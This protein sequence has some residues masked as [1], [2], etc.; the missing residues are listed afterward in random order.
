MTISKNRG[1]FTLV[2][3]LVVIAI[4]GTLVGLLLP[5]VQQAREAAR[6]STC[7]NNLKQIGLGLHQYADKRQKNGD[8]MMPMA[9]YSN[10]GSGNAIAS[11]AT[12]SYSWVV[13]IL[14]YADEL[15]TF[16]AIKDSSTNKA[17]TYAA[18]PASAGDNVRIPWAYC[19]TWTGSGKDKSGTAN[20]G[21][22]SQTGQITY[23]AQIGPTGSDGG[24]AAYAETPFAQ[25]RDGTTKTIMLL[26]NA[27]AVAYYQ[28][29]VT[30]IQN[31]TGGTWG[32]SS[33]SGSTVNTGN[34]AGAWSEHPGAL[35]G[36]GMVDGSTRFLQVDMDTNILQSLC[37][38]N[39]AEAIGDY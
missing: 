23:R 8:N 25:Y 26:E 18:V 33:W 16:N 3:L 17:M 32:G 20:G 39:G 29:N 6:R 14:P 11:T 13:L 5:A 12:A 30:W 22:T 35:F 21:S 15:N 36:S 28:G 19:P 2:E 27:K 10:S 7:G 4:I 24:F 37:T 1:G 31:A 38:R 34:V 9:L